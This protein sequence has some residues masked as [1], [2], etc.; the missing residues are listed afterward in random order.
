MTSAIIAWIADKAASYLFDAIK[1]A[2]FGDAAD[3]VDFL[4]EQQDEVRRTIETLALEGRIYEAS[5][6]IMDWTV[7]LK[8]KLAIADRG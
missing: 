2:L 3:K 5:Q 7:Q 6:H 4:I 8:E 1:D